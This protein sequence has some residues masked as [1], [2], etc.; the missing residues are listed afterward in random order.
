MIKTYK[1]A[2]DCCVIKLSESSPFP[3]THSENNRKAGVFIFD[4]NEDRVLLVQSRGQYWGAPKGTLEENE[5]S[6]DCALREVKEETGIELKTENLLKAIKVNNRA[7][8]F[9]TEMKANNVEVQNIVNNDANGI[10]WIKI[11]CLI[12]CI[13]KGEMVINK[14][15]KILFKKF[16]KIIIDNNTDF[17]KIK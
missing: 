6:C 13:N 1:C 7:V 11:K 3:P 14:H 8:Y 17:T 9:Y 4:P 16:L 12:N 10:T 2:E 15:C 5:T